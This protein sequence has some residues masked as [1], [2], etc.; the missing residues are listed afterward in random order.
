MNKNFANIPD[1]L[2]D[3]PVEVQSIIEKIQSIFNHRLVA[4]AI[5]IGSAARGEMSF[6]GKC[7]ELVIRSDLEFLVISKAPAR[8]RSEI[9]PSIKAL[10]QEN[11]LRWPEFH[12]D[13]SYLSVSRFK[14]LPFWIRHFELQKN[15]IVLS[16][17]D[18]IEKAPEVNLYNL[19]WTELND[20]ILWR[21]LNLISRLPTSWLDNQVELSINLLH[22][23]TRNLLDI[24]LWGLPGLGILLPSFKQRVKRWGD[25]DV[26]RK[27]DAVGFVNDKTLQGCLECRRKILVPFSADEIFASNVRTY[28]LAYDI[29]VG[30]KKWIHKGCGRGFQ[31]PDFFRRARAAFRIS[32]ITPSLIRET[33][34]RGPNTLAVAAARSLSL[35]ALAL[36]QGSDP[37]GHIEATA[38]IIKSSYNSK[39]II[40][41]WKKLRNKLVDYIDAVLGQAQWKRCVP[42]EDLE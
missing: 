42:K 15:G 39:N 21:L 3:L 38:K 28:S 22:A 24:T 6:S 32:R 26:A 33:F 5:L 7:Q 17:D 4:S 8:L 11:I 14:R 37:S 2:K 29:A 27:V 36:R 9:S 1:E 25:P 19:D 16:G 34:L 18:I 41:A 13:I 31:H 12:I 10:E 23:M 20:V 40:Y 30:N 35:G